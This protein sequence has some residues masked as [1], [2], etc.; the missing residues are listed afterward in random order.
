ML[1]NFK[2]FWVKTS[3]LTYNDYNQKLTSQWRQFLQHNFKRIYPPDTMQKITVK[4]K[5]HGYTGPGK[6]TFPWGLE[7]NYN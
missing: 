4:S 5:G 6:S 1:T 2:I 7:Q 3:L